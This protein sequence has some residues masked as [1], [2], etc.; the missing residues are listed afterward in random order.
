MMA[1]HVRARLFSLLT[2]GALVA[3]A[4][5]GPS[6]I[7]AGKLKGVDHGTTRAELLERIGQ[8]TLTAANSVDSVRLVNGHLH[9]VFLSKGEQ[10]EVIWLRET[11]GSLGDSLSRTT[12]TPIVLH[13]DTVEGWGWKFFEKRSLET[14]IPNPYRPSQPAQAPA[15][16]S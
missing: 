1:S 12:Q 13:A 2:V 11:P 5:C 7:G 8:G 3:V 15:T 4:A 9:Q 10:Y 14:G 16:K 6:D